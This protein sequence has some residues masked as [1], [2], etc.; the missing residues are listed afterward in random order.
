MIRSWLH[1]AILL[2]LLVNSE[3]LSSNFRVAKNSILTSFV[4]RRIERMHGS[5]FKRNCIPT[6]SDNKSATIS[7]GYIGHLDICGLQKEWNGLSFSSQMSGHL[8]EAE[9]DRIYQLFEINMKDWYEKNWGLKEIEKKKELYNTESHFICVHK[10]TGLTESKVVESFGSSASEQEGIEGNELVAFVM[11]RF[12][13]DDEDDPEFPVLFCY[14]IQICDAYRGQKIGRHV[15]LGLVGFSFPANFFNYRL[16]YRMLQMSRYQLMDLQA[17]I[18][19]HWSKKKVML[20]C[21]KN[22]IP[23]MAFYDK[24]GYTIDSTSPSSFGH[25]NELYEIL[26]IE[27]E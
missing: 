4:E 3:S 20:T 23:A 9:K 6:D 15:S 11:Y 1:L 24:I 21:F 2:L 14:E 13:Y 8:T 16:I 19:K 25:M 10:S 12:E 26:S 18:A 5:G 22:N 7:A 27:P 17:K